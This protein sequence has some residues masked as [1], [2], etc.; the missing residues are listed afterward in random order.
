MLCKKGVQ[1]TCL[2]QDHGGDLL[3]GELVAATEVLNLDLGGAVLVDDLEGPRLHILLDGRVI[4]AATDETP[5]E[6]M[7]AAV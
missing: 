1:G 3:G 4:E 7:L 2:G 6:T 5:E